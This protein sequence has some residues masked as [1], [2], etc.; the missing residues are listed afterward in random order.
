MTRPGRGL[1]LNQAYA[2]RT[3][4]VRSSPGCAAC[5]PRG[6]LGR[7]GSLAPGAVRRCIMLRFDGERKPLAGGVVAPRVPRLR[8]GEGGRGSVTI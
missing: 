8:Q 3:I 1:A 7:H 5:C 4:L 6:M 2:G